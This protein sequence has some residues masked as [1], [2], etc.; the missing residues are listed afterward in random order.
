[1]KRLFLTTAVGLA[2]VLSG[3]KN[4][5]SKSNTPTTEEASEK[6]EAGI[7]GEY[8]V[9]AEESVV[10]WVGS[11]PTGKHNGTVAVKEGKVTVKDGVVTGGEFVL[12]MNTI[13]VLDLTSDDGKENL[14]DHLKGTG[15]EE[16]QDH[17]FNV[18]QFPTATFVL[19]SFDGK[20]A[21]GDLTVKGTTK[22]VSFPALVNISDNEFSLVSESF[23]INR[24][25]FGVNYASKSLFDNLKDKFI[26][27]E[28]ELVVKAKATK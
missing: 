26:D 20:N 6:I 27:D 22:A 12:D 25:E 17:F 3:C 9:I 14:E 2:V 23:K 10:A 5:N 19:K 11:K 7:S 24:I 21:H 18:K 1:M 28:I 16:A 13:T 4:N 15:K 8:K